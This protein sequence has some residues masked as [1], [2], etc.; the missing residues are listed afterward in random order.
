MLTKFITEQKLKW[1]NDNKVYGEISLCVRNYNKG[2]KSFNKISRAEASQ[3]MAGLLIGK[4]GVEFCKTLEK[5]INKRLKKEN[6]EKN[7]YAA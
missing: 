2:K 3:I 5:I 7:K 1:L 6:F 4:H